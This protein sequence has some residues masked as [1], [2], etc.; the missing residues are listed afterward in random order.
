MP[1]IVLGPEE[2]LWGSGVIDIGSIVKN[3]KFSKMSVKTNKA[4]EYLHTDLAP[5][6][7]KLNGETWKKLDDKL[8]IA[9]TGTLKELGK[10]KDKSWKNVVASMMKSP[11]LQPDPN[12]QN[13]FNRANKLINESSAD[14]K[15]DGSPDAVIISEVKT[16]FT[17]L[18]QDLD[19]LASTRIDT[20][21]LA[22]IVAQSG[23]IIDSFEAFFAKKERHEKTLL[24]IGALRFPDLETPYLKLYRIQL[25]AWSDSSRVPFHQD[26][27]NGITGEFNSRVFRPTFG[28]HR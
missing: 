18:I 16:W 17:Q 21:V 19:F 9:V 14:F 13:E 11:L 4:A 25:S 7:R 26:N 24:D 5:S 2:C 12:P 15:C 8:K 10:V 22:K 1:L 23:A 20:D 28:C 3:F 6:Y 27:K